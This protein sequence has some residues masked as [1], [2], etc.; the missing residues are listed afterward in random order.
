MSTP[1]SHRHFVRCRASLEFHWLRAPVSRHMKLKLEDFGPLANHRIVANLKA[2]DGLNGNLNR[3]YRVKPDF[4]INDFIAEVAYGRPD[5][6]RLAAEGLAKGIS[7]ELK[8][9][10]LFELLGQRLRAAADSFLASLPYSKQKELVDDPLEY[11]R[12][13]SA[14]TDEDRLLNRDEVAQLSPDAKLIYNEITS[15]YLDGAGDSSVGPELLR[16][17][18]SLELESS[19]GALP[20]PTQQLLAKVRDIIGRMTPAAR[21]EEDGDHRDFRLDQDST[22]ELSR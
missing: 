16:D 13:F 14:L 2:A 10:P 21:D 9:Q 7:T 4:D 20:P 15:Q 18:E 17:A 5:G 19:G 11:L 12:D 8:G 22:E 6:W 3:L 1:S